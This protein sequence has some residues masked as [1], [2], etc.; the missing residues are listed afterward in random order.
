MQVAV[1][2]TPGA[3][4]DQDGIVGKLLSPLRLCRGFDRN[5]LIW[6]EKHGTPSFGLDT[7]GQINH[8]ES[9]ATGETYTNRA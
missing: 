3:L 9:S 8:S 7:P 6:M 5:V 4:P 1:D 2:R